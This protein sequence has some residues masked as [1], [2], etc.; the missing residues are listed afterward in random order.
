M[1]M[2]GRKEAVSADV[3]KTT[4][5]DDCDSLENRRACRHKQKRKKLNDIGV[6]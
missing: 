2:P 4:A 5:K 3:N 6:I 1:T